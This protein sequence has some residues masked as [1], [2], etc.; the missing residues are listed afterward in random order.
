MA[1]TKRINNTIY[2]RDLMVE[3]YS[4]L[5]QYSDIVDNMIQEKQLMI[6]PAAYVYFPTTIELVA[7]GNIKE[8]VCEKLENMKLELVI[9]IPLHHMIQRR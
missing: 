5:V 2:L 1:S 3:I 7:D 6:N 4:I 8:K 9:T